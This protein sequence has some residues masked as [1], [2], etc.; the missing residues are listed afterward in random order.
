MRRHD[1]DGK[2]PKVSFFFN[3][4]LTQTFGRVHLNKWVVEVLWFVAKGLFYKREGE[5]D[6]H[7]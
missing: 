5:Q 6:K 7:G 4:N 1:K 3:M 2:V